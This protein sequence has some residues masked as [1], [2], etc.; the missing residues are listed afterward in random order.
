MDT[1]RVD[2]HGILLSAVA[3]LHFL[4]RAEGLIGGAS[5]FIDI[6]HA[7]GSASRTEPLPLIDVRSSSVRRLVH[8]RWE[9]QQTSGQAKVNTLASAAVSSTSSIAPAFAST[10]A[11]D[12]AAGASADAAA[13]SPAASQLCPD[14]AELVRHLDVD[15]DGSVSRCEMGML[16][17]PLADLV[18]QEGGRLHALQPGCRELYQCL[19]VPPP[20]PP[21]PLSAE[22]RTPDC[23]RAPGQSGAAPSATDS[24][25]VGG[26][27]ALRSVDSASTHREEEVDA[28]LC[29]RGDLGPFPC[30]EP[31]CEKYEAVISCGVLGR[32]HDGCNSKFAELWTRPQRWAA[33]MRVW[34]ACPVAC[35]LCEL[36]R[37]SW[38]SSMGGSGGGGG[39]CD[40]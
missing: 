33:N 2:A 40:A 19:E 24:V 15:D 14:C 29:Q 9:V 23:V 13:A 6:A 20:E 21:S 36:Q 28:A 18:R 35:G 3:D 17:T 1:S 10:Q 37:R 31:G 8:Q 11:A 12:A 30:F 32:S 38:R 4:A 26:S 34:E 5:T 39:S 27:G 25:S 7:L 22:V 16:Y